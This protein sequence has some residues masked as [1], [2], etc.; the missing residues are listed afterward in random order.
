MYIVQGSRAFTVPRR[1]FMRRD[2]VTTRVRRYQVRGSREAAFPCTCICVWYQVPARAIFM[3]RKSSG[4]APL[5]QRRT[6]YKK[7]TH[8]YIQVHS[9]FIWFIFHVLLYVYSTTKQ[10]FPTAQRARPPMRHI[11][12]AFRL[13]CHCFCLCSSGAYTSSSRATFSS[14]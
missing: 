8:M 10:T 1:K 3:N 9:C 6:A 5:A 14:S 13:F 4:C 2:I 11:Y 7:Y 12:R